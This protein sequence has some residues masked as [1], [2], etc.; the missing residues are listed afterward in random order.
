MTALNLKPQS[1]LHW[2][3]RRIKM[4][5]YILLL[6]IGLAIIP[7][8]FGQ[9]SFRMPN[10]SFEIGLMDTS[11]NLSNDFMPI[12]DFFQESIFIDLDALASGFKLGLGFGISPVSLNINTR[13]WGFGLY[14]RVEATGSVSLAGEMLSLNL[15]NPGVYKSEAS[16]ALFAITG[17]DTYFFIQDFKVTLNP[18]VFLA[19]A[20][21]RPSI[22]Y[23][24]DR[25]EDN[26][27]IGVNVKANMDFY[28]AYPYDKLMNSMI[29]RMD[30]SGIFSP[31][32]GLGF[33]F[34]VG[35][36]YPISQ[37]TG[38][39]D[40]SPLLDFDVGINLINVPILPS[41]ARNRMNMEAEVDVNLPLDGF[42]FGDLSDILN[43]SESF[44]AIEDGNADVER[45]FKVI[46]WAN[47]RPFGTQFLTLTPSLGF[48]ISRHFYDNPFSLE[49]GLDVTLDLINMLKIKAGINYQDRTW[50][51]SINVAFNLMILEIYAGAEFRSQNFLKSFGTAGVGLNVGLKL[52]F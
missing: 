17:I 14:T 11:I 10:R 30:F 32:A 26:S 13:T 21:A 18:A 41:I 31:T 39:R 43:M 40:R 28:T 42:N 33:D 2:N 37:A 45:P 47:W 38:L 19:I 52:G 22:T 9:N 46:L 35:I 29:G 20:Y 48:A 3:Y 7:F 44:R 5:R 12:F 51:N 4:K 25:P 50:I 23:R 8:A 16:F 15:N 49:T 24:L 34:S 27:M 6:I 1:A 36:E